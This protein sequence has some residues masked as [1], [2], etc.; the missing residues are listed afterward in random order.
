M[1]GMLT[2]PSVVSTGLIYYTA[3]TNI[4]CTLSI[5]NSTIHYSSTIR[6]YSHQKLYPHCIKYTIYFDTNTT[7]YISDLW[8]VDS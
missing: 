6:P 5:I 3:L 7:P 2:K 8:L 4:Y 1:I